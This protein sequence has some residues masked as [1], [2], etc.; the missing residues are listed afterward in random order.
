MNL[1]D[2]LIDVIVAGL[3]LYLAYQAMTI[4]KT[5]EV[6]GTILVGKTI[7]ITRKSDV[8]GYINYMCPKAFV[9]GLLVT[10]T[11][12][13][14]VAFYFLKLDKPRIF[15]YFGFGVVVIGF[16][17]LISHAQK[18]FLEESNQ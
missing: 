1:M 9:F 12:I 3:G 7:E 16:C 4:K 13:I 10:L 18:K 5:G 17:V 14:Q 15:L 11:S 2:V 8:Q 6:K